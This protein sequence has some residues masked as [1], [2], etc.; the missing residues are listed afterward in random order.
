MATI[1]KTSV[2]IA[3]LRIDTGFTAANAGGDA[4][5][6]GSGVALLV[7]NTG[8]SI[9]LTMA[10]PKKYDGDRTL[11]GRDHTIPA[12]TGEFVIPLR[13]EYRDPATGLAS[14]TYSA[15]PTGVTVAVVSVP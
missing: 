6:T 9:T 3:G 7:K 2:G 5:A 14:W 8:S 12:T 11:T 15:T 13:D 10:Y 1:A 4:A